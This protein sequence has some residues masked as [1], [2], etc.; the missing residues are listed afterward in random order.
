MLHNLS[1]AAVVIDALRVNGSIFVYNTGDITQGRKHV[2]FS[3]VF[4]LE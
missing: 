3:I 1:S 2:I 4:S